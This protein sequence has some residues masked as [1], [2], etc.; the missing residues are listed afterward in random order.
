MRIAFVSQEYPPE[1]AK[2]GIGTQTY[3]K[4]HGL[5]RLGHEVHVISRSPDNGRHEYR[6]GPVSVTRL[7]VALAA[8]TEVADWITYSGAVATELAAVHEVTPPDLVDFPEWGGEAYVH[9]LNRTEF[10][11]IPTT[12]Q[13]HGPLVMLAHTMGWPDKTSELYHAGIHMEATC[14]RLADA[15]YASSDCSADWCATHYGRPRNEIPRLHTG[16]DTSLFCP[17]PLPKESRPTIIFAGRIV[18]N[19]GVGILLEAACELARDFP[20]LQVRILGRGEKEV[21]GELRAQAS[22]SG[23]PQVLDLVGFVD[24][25]EMPAHLSRGHVFAAPSRYEGGPGFVLL[26]AM[27]C[28]LPVVACEGS[29]AAEVIDPGRTGFLV[30]PDDARTLADVLRPLLADPARCAELGAC[31]R[32]FVQSEADS[33]VCLKRLEAFYAAACGQPAELEVTAR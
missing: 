33:A 11:R 6:D 4:A 16:V 14:V 25:R 31:G 5:A 28:G 17:Q 20:D 23:L 8:Y 13:L 32:R 27:A 12:V 30:P 9:L 10:N 24:R 15:V 26:E 22:R 19:K 29:G 7:P 21:V 1:T 2:G 3:L 18:R